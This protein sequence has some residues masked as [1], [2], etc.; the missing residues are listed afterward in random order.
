MERKNI[1]ALGRLLVFASLVLFLPSVGRDGIN[2]TENS[3]AN[4]ASV[5]GSA[6][7][8]NAANTGENGGVGIRCS[9]GGYVSGRVGTLDGG[10]ANFDATCI[11]NLSP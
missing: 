2:V 11:N 3:G 9:I 8:L 6:S 4:L 7:F 5:G 10:A 1:C